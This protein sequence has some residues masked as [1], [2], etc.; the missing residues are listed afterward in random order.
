MLSGVFLVTVSSLLLLAGTKTRH[1]A[2]KRE[3]M[4]IDD[5]KM[6]PVFGSIAL[7]GMFFALKYIPK[8]VLNRVFNVLFSITGVVS[9]Y[10]ALTMVYTEAVLYLLKKQDIPEG[11]PQAE[12][13]GKEEAKPEKS[14]Q[15]EHAS[16]P[17][18]TEAPSSAG[19]SKSAE[20]GAKSGEE[21]EKEKGGEKEK[22][23]KAKSH[24]MSEVKKSVAEVKKAIRELS[25][26][27]WR[28]P[29]VILFGF[30]VCINAL[31]VKNK[32]VILGNILA[33][34]FAITGLQEIKPDSTHTVLLLLA[35]LFVYDIFWVFCT[36]V[37]IGVAKGLDFPIKIVCPFRG[38]GASM[39]GL[40]DI[41][42]PGLYLGVARDFAEKKKASWV[43][44]LGFIGYVISLI[45]TFGVVFFFKRGQPALLY[46]CP[47][48]VGST[49]LGA[50]MHG[51]TKE[52]IAYTT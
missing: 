19:A 48:I 11:K 8:D 9:V 49:L 14:E 24:F 38:M 43:F 29:N 44:L 27:L 16:T 33:A 46:I 40:G 36:P 7:L 47:I 5:A 51:K 39:I 15:S 2:E 23:P 32:G 20:A 42:V 37:M 10:K 41:V 30:S 17:K 1:T 28:F 50:C 12:K 31:Y 45:V 13:E 21:K 52:F 6:F 35:L 18:S 34:S 22:E 25:D 4:S 3:S 26:E